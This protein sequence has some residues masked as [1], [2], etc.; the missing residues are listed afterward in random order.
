MTEATTILV[1][2][3][4]R[5]SRMMVSKIIDT[6]LPGSRIIEADSGEDALAKISAENSVD[7]M[8]IDYN[9]PGMNG[10]ELAS[11]LRARFAN[12]QICLLTANIQQSTQQK[13]EQENILFFKKPVTEDRV[14]EILATLEG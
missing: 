13:A 5:V 1:C 7:L 10:L 6:H 4:S 8:I 3:D 12:T 11:Q 2:D 9:M 14:K